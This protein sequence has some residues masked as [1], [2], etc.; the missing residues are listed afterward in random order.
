MKKIFTLLYLTLLFSNLGAQIQ[1]INESFVSPFSPSSAGWVLQNNSVPLGSGAWGQGTGT[2]FAA[3]SGGQ[4]DYAAVNFNSQAPT[5]GNISNFFISPTITLVNGGVLE[6][7]SRTTN[8][9]ASFPD[10]LEVRYA[11]GTGT[12]AIGSGTAAVGAFTNTM[13]V[14][15]P[16]LTSTGYPDTWT[17]YSY[18]LSGITGTV[19]GRFAFRYFVDDGG[20]NGTNSDY[21]GI[22]DVKYTVPGPCSPPNVTVSPSS[23][24]ICGA[25][26]NITLTASGAT[27]YSWT[28]SPSLLFNFISPTAV[29]VS[30]SVTTTFTL[31]GNNVPNC[32]GYAVTTVSVVQIPTVTVANATACPGGTVMLTA[33]G[34]NTYSWSTGGTGSSEV[35]TA[36]NSPVMGVVVTG[37]NA[38]NCSNTKT[39]TVTS[40]TFLTV[41]STSVTLCPDV[42]TIIGASGA[43]GYT[44]ST[45]ATTQSVVITPTNNMVLSVTG[46]S[47]GCTDSKNIYITVDPNMFAPSFTTCA[48]TSATLVAT[49][50]N[51]YSWST[52]ATASMIVVSPT[53]T[54]IYTVVGTSGSCSQT[55]T[56]SVKIGVNLSVATT[57]TCF[58]TNLVIT[59]Y[60]ASSYT[61]QP[62]NDFNSSVIVSP[63]AATVYTVTG[64]T[65]TCTGSST[66]MV[67]FCAGVEE[68]K[69]GIQDVSV[70][71][72]P[73]NGELNIENATGDL[74]VLNMM[75]QI[76]LS[77]SL[78][79]NAVINTG[80]FESGTYFLIITDTQRN[81][82]KIIK[83]IKD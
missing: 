23:P 4:D 9:P 48:G 50:A 26:G 14:I 75:G 62:I 76:V 15:N 66:V 34:A 20:Q 16:N 74:K 81:T 35:V 59:A 19:A 67:A 33:S 1:Q 18:T 11:V 61:W 55:K 56:V 49:G 2:V 73:F 70:F 32:T 6:F 44:W 52:G 54:T 7:Y 83:V 63:T 12:G 69:F 10:R 60:G 65:G 37:Y 64:K 5:L 29:V 3:N 39:I 42:A 8:N 57:Q 13:V 31:A 43:T 24:A 25:S 41:P 71:P 51:S 21:I 80:H 40:N 72:N 46:S 79:G 30:P 58:G 68:L 17:L 45:G 47:A 53:A 28:S 38:P 27:N 77:T 36:T 82:R 22:D 78:E